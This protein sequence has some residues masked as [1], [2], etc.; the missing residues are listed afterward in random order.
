MKEFERLFLSGLASAL[1]EEI[2]QLRGALCFGLATATKTSRDKLHQA[3]EGLKKCWSEMACRNLLSDML[4]ALKVIERDRAVTGN[5]HVSGLCGYVKCLC[6]A[7]L[8]IHSPS[9]RKYHAALCLGYKVK[10]AGP[11]YSGDIDDYQDMVQR[12][13]DLKAA[14]QAAYRLADDMGKYN[15]NNDML[16][17]FMAPEFFFRGRNGAYD[18][19]IVPGLLELMKEEIDKPIYNDWLFV[20][21]TVIAATSVELCGEKGCRAPLKTEVDKATKKKQRKCTRD[22][23]HTTIEKVAQV[24]N[25]A[26]VCKQR[27]THLVAKEQISNVDF[28]AKKGL[29]DVVTVGG[30]QLERYRRD[31][32]AADPKK[33]AFKDERMGGTIFTIDGVTFGLEVCLDHDCRIDNTSGQ[34]GRLQHAAN[35]QIQLIPSAGMSIKA[36]RTVPGGITFNVDGQTP[37]CHVLRS[38]IDDIN[39][40]GPFHSSGL[41]SLSKSQ[42]EPLSKSQLEPLSKSQKFM[43]ALKRAFG[44]PSA[45]PLSSLWIRNASCGAVVGLGPF[46]IPDV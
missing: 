37:H 28:V 20:L 23:K 10:T 8:G 2:D 46:D 18:H 11:E 15:S 13:N 24:D 19:A 43:N 4:R 45:S 41:K 3:N 33:T 39:Q 27:E 5:V 21:G 1:I 31:D 16:K 25:I 40:L 36:F 42:L 34:G 9:R 14:V 29:K 7:H 38:R 6:E 32:W 30:E 26:L 12:C 17:I 35:I 44:M 22:S